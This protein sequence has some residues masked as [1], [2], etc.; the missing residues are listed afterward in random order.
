MDRRKKLRIVCWIVAFLSLGFSITMFGMSRGNFAFSE[1]YGGDAYTGIQNAAALATQNIY[2]LNSIVRSGFGYL[3]LLI[4]IC[5]FGAIF[6]LRDSKKQSLPSLPVVTKE[7][8]VEKVEEV[9]EEKEEVSEEKLGV[10]KECE[11]SESKEVTE[12]KIEEEEE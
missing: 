8:E 1:S 12:T 6:V 9:K 4:S 2:S 3:F 11:A 10:S 7:K 5:N